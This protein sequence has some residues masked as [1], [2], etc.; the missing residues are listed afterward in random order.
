MPEESPFNIEAIQ[1]IIDSFYKGSLARV[2]ISE[3]A[4][5]ELHNIRRKQLETFSEGQSSEIK[6]SYKFA[7]D[8][9]DEA[10]RYNSTP[11]KLIKAGKILMELSPSQKLILAFIKLEERSAGNEFEKFRSDIRKQVLSLA[12]GTKNIDNKGSL[13]EIIDQAFADNP[14]LKFTAEVATSEMIVMR[15]VLSG[16]VLT[17]QAM[18][19]HMIVGRGILYKAIIKKQGSR[20][21]LWAIQKRM[22]KIMSD[23]P[24]EISGLASNAIPLGLAKKF[25]DIC[26]VLINK[27]E[28]LAKLAKEHR[29]D[30]AMLLDFANTYSQAIHA[31]ILWYQKMSLLH[32]QAF[33]GLNDPFTAP[34]ENNTVSEASETPE[35]SS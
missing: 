13:S 19:I 22:V 14:D 29:E 1:R 18:C 33:D 28:S 34:K 30:E 31:W 9:L 16:Y 3:N 11:F 12:L 27:E 15:D 24:T 7:I 35:K 21:K 4:A 32:K 8:L 23:L 2:L 20:L 17:M 6:S 25:F 10:H 26:L 5:D